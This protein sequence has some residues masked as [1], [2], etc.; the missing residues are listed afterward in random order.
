MLSGRVSRQ[1]FSP[2]GLCRNGTRLQRSQECEG[3]DPG[4]CG[5]GLGWAG[6]LALFTDT[7]YA[8]SR[9][10]NPQKVEQMSAESAAHVR[11]ARKGWDS[12][13]PLPPGRL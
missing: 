12:A 7:G 5:R 6:P 13:T 1:E 9:A 3:T 10:N 8:T 2:Y 11:E 4:P